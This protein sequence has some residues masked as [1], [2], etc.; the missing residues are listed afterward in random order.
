MH[1]AH[2]RWQEHGLEFSLQNEIFD[3]LVL[4]QLQKGGDIWEN[5]ANGFAD[6]LYALA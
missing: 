1:L 5:E 2:E 4:I 3:R 6:R